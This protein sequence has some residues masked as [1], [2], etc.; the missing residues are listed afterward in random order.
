MET[1]YRCSVPFASAPERPSMSNTPS[2]E[3]LASATGPAGGLPRLVLVCAAALAASVGVCRLI[4][5]AD[6]PVFV[7]N[8]QVRVVECRIPHSGRIAELH[9]NVGDCVASD[10]LLGEIV[11]DHHGEALE[12]QRHTVQALAAELEQAQAKARIELSWRLRSLESEILRTQL[13]LANYMKEKFACQMRHKAWEQISGSEEGRPSWTSDDI[14]VQSLVCDTSEARSGRLL[15]MLE[16]EDAANSAEVY[17][18][19][20]ELC[21]ARIEQLNTLKDELPDV[22]KCAS[23]VDL[24]ETRLRQARADLESLEAEAGMLQLRSSAY[25]EVTGLAV[26]E[27]DEVR[28]GDLAVRLSDPHQKSVLVHI[29]SD[30]IPHF[31]PGVSV[32]LVFPGDQKRQGRVRD[33]A[34]VCTRAFGNEDAAPLGGDA[35]I[36]IEIDPAGKLWPEVP[37]GAAVKVRRPDAGPTAE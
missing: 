32:T 27:G 6:G 37:V 13:D 33:V 16:H 26:A 7:G 5:P 35:L 3:F 24:L 30:Q 28:A 9:V 34:G 10:Q 20:I 11:D 19:Q 17:S 2:E 14:I 25:G 4:D 15:A 21:D 8:L 1:E 18:V 29:P 22:V 31:R 36:P 12:R 23:G